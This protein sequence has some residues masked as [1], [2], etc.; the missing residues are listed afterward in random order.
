[1][2]LTTTV[3]FYRM[4]TEIMLHFMCE[5]LSIRAMV[6]ELTGQPLEVSMQSSRLSPPCSDKLRGVAQLSELYT[7]IIIIYNCWLKN[8]L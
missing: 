3:F 5:F 1:M 2:S 6:D 8:S 7:G 4:V